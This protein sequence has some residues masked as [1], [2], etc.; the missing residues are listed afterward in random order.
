[1]VNKESRKAEINVS[2]LRAASEE[3]EQLTTQGSIV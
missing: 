3:T 1:M 2:M